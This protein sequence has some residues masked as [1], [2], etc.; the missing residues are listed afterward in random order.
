MILKKPSEIPDVV[1]GDKVVALV[2]GKG[3]NIARV[4]SSVFGYHGY[5]CINILGGEVGR[6]IE[7]ECNAQKM[8][9]ENF[10]IS[11]SNRINTALV[12][13]YE[14]RMLMINEPGP[15]IDH[16]EKNSFITFFE[17]KLTPGVNI[18]ISGSAPRGFESE[19]MMRLLDIAEHSN[20]R[21]NIDVAG[22]WL[23]EI[24]SRSPDLLK[25]N[26]DEFKASFGIEKGDLR[27]MEEFRLAHSIKDLVITD[28]KNGSV[29]LCDLEK[30]R[31]YSSVIRSRFS[32][33]SGD[34]FFGGLLYGQQ[35]GMSHT[36]SLRLATACGA[37]NT[38]SYGAAQFELC[39]VEKTID[40]V[41]VR[42]IKC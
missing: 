38:I 42:R 36:E 33:G 22:N 12:Y 13:E 31:A 6:I 5:S 11:G 4:F 7:S 14:D 9:T 10:W 41:V 26:A 39:D 20:C 21:L 2:D 8:K 16:E 23:C 3:L 1:R 28:G 32:V 29:W 35:K 34:S 25:V 27:S 30:L 15:I 37:A 24:V 17:E 18:I 19:D 40:E